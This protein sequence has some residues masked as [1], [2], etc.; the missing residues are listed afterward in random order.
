MSRY[1]LVAS[2][3]DL[4][5]ATM[6]DHLT[7]EEGFG[8]D[9]LSPRYG[10]IALHVTKES[11]LTLEDLDKTYPDARAFV[12]LSK[13][14]SDSGIPTLTCHCTGNFSDAPFGGNPGEIAMAWPALQKAYLKAIAKAGVP[15]YDVIIEATHHGPTS[16]AKPVLFIELGSSEKQW[17][18][19]NAAK[20]MCRCI[21]GV[22]QDV[23]PCKKVGIAIGGTHYPT[24][25]NKLLLESDFGL[26][27][28]ASKHSLG[29][30]D[31]RMLDQ[32]I[33]KSSEKVTHV[34]LDAKGLG[35]HKDRITKLA[36]KT[37]LEVMKV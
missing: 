21:L 11:L 7:S 33:R 36:E 26:A 35:S 13:H 2:S 34:I 30:I 3:Q 10:D 6:I 12:F 1:I 20:A 17:A 18:D 5:G 25:F 27:A 14:R 24:K 31:E 15:G 22:L 23:E 8:P 16:L 4:A 29:A 19:R 37:G 9:G 32:M 28:V